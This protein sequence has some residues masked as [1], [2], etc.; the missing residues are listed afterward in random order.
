MPSVLKDKGERVRD[1]VEI[2]TQLKEV[3]IPPSDPGYVAT[4]Q[5]LDA[6]IADGEPRMEKIP[7]PRALRVAHVTLPRLAGRK[8]TFFLKAT[9]EL[10]EAL[11]ERD[12]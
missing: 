1:A 4:K 5:L 6:W 9:D 2:L 11:K 7:F 3:G 8:V 10:R 12:F